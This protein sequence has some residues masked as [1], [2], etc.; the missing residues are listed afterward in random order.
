MIDD[1]KPYPAMKDCDVPWLGAMPSHWE[2]QRNGRLFG[3][4]KDV[5]FPKLPI[6]EVS[7]R[8]GV[9]RR[10]L[11][12]GARKQFMAD[13]SQ[14]LRAARG[15][16]AYNM[17]RMWQG[18]VGV[19]PTDGLVSPAYIVARP[20]EGVHA[21]YFAYLFRT[22]AYMREVEDYSRGIVPDRNR[23]Y[24][25][26]FKQLASIVP[27][28]DEQKFIVRFLDA[29]GSL[30]ARVVHTK[31]KLIVLLNE[32]KQAIIR[33]A[34]THGVDPSIRFK[35]SGA[36]W[37]GDVPESW[38]VNRLKWV[39][40][41]QR[42]YDLPTDKRIQGPYPVVSSGGVIDRHVEAKVSAPGVVIGRYGST[43][44]VFFME[45]D[46]WPHNT[47]L[48]VTD[49]QGNDPR[50]CFFLLRTISKADH[51]GKSAVPGVD[52]KDLFDIVVP[53]PPPAEQQS[54]VRGIEAALLELNAATQIIG[55]Q[56]ALLQEFRTRLI[57]NVVTGK[58]DVRGA[59]AALPK[60]V[61]ESD[62]I[63]TPETELE[64]EALDEV[65]A[66]EAAA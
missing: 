12:N 17:M 60:T 35:P 36:E 27:S 56:I 24:W 53:L 11:D 63:E 32:Q 16:I 4:R 5:G 30:T 51:A 29:H 66:E 26:S 23:L 22:A 57:T 34:V 25:E 64:D 62:A 46:F 52:R 61:E 48:F 47:S 50:W 33:R 39:T 13:R 31:R 15:D 43:D 38:E 10:D 20:Y 8:S 18:A 59:A 45:E 6:L 55:R 28:S 58:L 9:R 42:G 49:F 44:A 41:L 2:I 3:L 65:E 19:V 7:I 54:I 1:L 14:Y 37:L 40:R 21:P